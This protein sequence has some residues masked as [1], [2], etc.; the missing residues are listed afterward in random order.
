MLGRDMAAWRGHGPGRRRSEG[1]RQ[2]NCTVSFELQLLLE[3]NQSEKIISWTR[4][5][6]AAAEPHSP[7]SSYLNFPGV[8]EDNE[9][10]VRKAYGTNYD[11]LV[12]IKRTYDPM[13]LFRMNQ[14]IKP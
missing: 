8:G 13:N 7:G 1:V 5:Q 3:P 14:N 4:S 2:A 11:R 10:L 6:I 12:K 9:D